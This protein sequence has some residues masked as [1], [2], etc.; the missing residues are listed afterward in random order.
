MKAFQAN[1]RANPPVGAEALDEAYIH[2]TAKRHTMQTLARAMRV[3][4]ATASRLLKTLRRKGI[5]IE[6][7]KEGRD[8][9]FAVCEDEEIAAAWEKDPLLSLVGIVKGPG[10]RGESVDDAVYGK[11]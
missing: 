9:F 5:R 3:S 11:G 4:I 8:W 10:R 6:S 2:L 1:R 7:M